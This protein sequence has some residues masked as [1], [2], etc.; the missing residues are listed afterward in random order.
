MPR[1]GPPMNDD[2]EQ[3]RCFWR[4]WRDRMDGGRMGGAS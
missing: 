2:E 4:Q 3:M 1:N